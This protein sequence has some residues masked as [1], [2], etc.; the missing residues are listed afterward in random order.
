MVYP[1][2][3]YQQNYIEMKETYLKHIYSESPKLHLF[4]SPGVVDKLSIGEK[5]EDGKGK[6]QNATNMQTGQLNRR[7]A[8]SS[9]SCFAAIQSLP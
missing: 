6:S 5:G 2:S 3:F 9:F 8:I 4:L 1:F 7:N